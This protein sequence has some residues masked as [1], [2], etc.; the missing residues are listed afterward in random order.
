[1]ARSREKYSLKRPEITSL[2]YICICIHITLNSHVHPIA[3]FSLGKLSIY[4][5]SYDK[6]KFISLGHFEILLKNIAFFFLFYL[7]FNVPHS[8]MVWTWQERD[9]IFIPKSFVLVEF[10]ALWY[11]E[12]HLTAYFS[13]NMKNSKNEFPD[14]KCYIIG[15]LLFWKIT[16]SLP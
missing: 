15:K 12:S 10:D 14:T 7:C 11:I 2:G 5:R 3:Y 4:V 9:L 6:I 16:F 8:L 1:M 13:S